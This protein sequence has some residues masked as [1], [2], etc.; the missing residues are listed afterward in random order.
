MRLSTL[1]FLCLAGFGFQSCGSDDDISFDASLAGSWSMEEGSA[2][3]YSTTTSQGTEY[4]ADFTNVLVEPTDYVITFHPDGRA[5]SEGTFSM[6][7][8]T[9]LNGQSSSRIIT[10]SDILGTG[11]WELNGNVL[12]TSDDQ[13]NTGKATILTLSETELAVEIDHEETRTGNGAESYQQQTALYTLS[14]VN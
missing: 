8:T 11:A 4:R 5:D 10:L 7:V 14:R 1:L 3:G 9:V 2:I 12:T 6:E 13:G